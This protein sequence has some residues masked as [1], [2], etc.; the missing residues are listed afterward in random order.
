MSKASVADQKLIVFNKL[1][2]ESKIG[3]NQNGKECMWKRL[4]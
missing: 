1:I 4:H 2:T 3:K